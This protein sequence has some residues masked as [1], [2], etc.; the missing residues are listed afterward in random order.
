MYLDNNTF[1]ILLLQIGASPNALEKKYIETWSSIRYTLIIINI[2]SIIFFIKLT[3]VIYKSISKLFT[4]AI[5]KKILKPTGLI[6]ITWTQNQ[7]DK[8]KNGFKEE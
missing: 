4:Y 7:G 8:L 3:K 5:M 1:H 6:E 2:G